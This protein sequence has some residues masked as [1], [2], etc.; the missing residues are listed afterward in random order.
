MFQSG[1]MLLM[2]ILISYYLCSS[3]SLVLNMGDLPLLNGLVNIQNEQ[4][5][6]N[7]L[8]VARDVLIIV[9]VNWF[10]HVYLLV[11]WDCDVIGNLV[12]NLFVV[13]WFLS[14]ALGGWSVW[15]WPRKSVDFDSW[16]GLPVLIM[17]VALAAVWSSLSGTSKVMLGSMALEE[18]WPVLWA[19]SGVHWSGN[20]PSSNTCVLETAC[21][22]CDASDAARF[23][24][25]GILGSGSCVISVSFVPPEN[26]NHQ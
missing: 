18:L 10:K 16:Q 19:G 12:S 5:L 24:L 25:M 20:M 6:W 4:L 3:F 9:K 7:F 26:P 14:F 2:R 21:G 22:L 11:L 13:I 15:L 17:M 8:W 23:L 1:N